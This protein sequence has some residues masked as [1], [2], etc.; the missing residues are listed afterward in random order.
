[1]CIRDRLEH[2]ALMKKG[3]RQ[4]IRLR[5]AYMATLEHLALMKK[6]L[7]RPLGT[8][9]PEWALNTLP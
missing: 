1:M 8:A 7:R 2:L 5:W 3:L 9:G 6:G 4:L